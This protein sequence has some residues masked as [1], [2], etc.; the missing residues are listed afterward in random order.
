MYKK[1][2]KRSLDLVLSA[3]GIVVLSPVYL[4]LSVAVLIGMGAPIIFSQERI[5]LG[6]RPFRF[7]KF[8]SMTNARDADGNLLDETKRLTKFGSFIRS[9]SLDELPELFLILTGKMS[10]V[11]P[12][13]LPVYYLPYYTQEERKRHTVR[14][15]LIPADTLSGKSLV[16]WDEQL[17]WDIYYAENCSFI[18][19]VKIILITFKVLFQR[20]KEDYGSS[21]RPHLNEER[22]GER[23]Q[24]SR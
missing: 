20:A 23:D 5:G 13:P 14:G 22:S 24:I 10:I 9:T 21:D 3:I 1:F 18:L 6:E 15:G 17:S 7:F 2:F 16:T 19:D 4:I 8:R 11:G 12:R